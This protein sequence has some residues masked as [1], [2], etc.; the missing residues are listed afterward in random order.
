MEPHDGI[1][2]LTSAMG[3]HKKNV[4]INTQQAGPHQEPN[5]LALLS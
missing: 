4:A 2:A 1:S 3:G 5:P